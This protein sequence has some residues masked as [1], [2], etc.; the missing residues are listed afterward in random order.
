MY[1]EEQN[2]QNMSGKLLFCAIALGALWG[3]LGVVHLLCAQL[4]CSNGAPKSLKNKLKHMVWDVLGDP[5]GETN[6]DHMDKTCVP[7]QRET[8]FSF[9]QSVPMQ[10]GAHFF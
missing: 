7:M 1:P 8:R 10:R 5:F 2:L 6:L 3:P 4:G 9:L